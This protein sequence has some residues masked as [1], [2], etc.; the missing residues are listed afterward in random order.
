MGSQKEHHLK[1]ERP[2]CH[3]TAPLSSWAQLLPAP[4]SAPLLFLFS[5]H[6]SLF[7]SFLTHFLPKSAAPCPCA[8][9]RSGSLAHISTPVPSNPITFTK[10][11]DIFIFFHLLFLSLPSSLHSF[12]TQI[13]SRLTVCKVCPFSHP[14][15]SSHLCTHLPAV[16]VT[17]F[18]Y[19]SGLTVHPG[20]KNVT[21]LP[22]FV[23]IKFHS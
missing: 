16:L 6:A 15:S 4:P 14:C 23:T 3:L 17:I 2:V 18:M 22:K 12:E 9:L 1:K 11:R 8:W 19:L 7:N 20:H 13:H 21:L 10:T 5:Y